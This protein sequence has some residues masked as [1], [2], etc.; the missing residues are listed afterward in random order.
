MKRLV[1]NSHSRIRDSKADRLPVG[2]IVVRRG[3][4]EKSIRA[5]IRV[6]GELVHQDW[7]IEKI[8]RKAAVRHAMAQRAKWEQKYAKRQKETTT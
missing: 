6:G 8:G 3:G 2:V 5:H 7:N 4:V 1:Q